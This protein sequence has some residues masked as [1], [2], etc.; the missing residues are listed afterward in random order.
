MTGM[1]EAGTGLEICH[2]PQAMATIEIEIQ[3]TVGPG[4]DPEHVQTETG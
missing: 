1:I 4:Q 2:F 3:A